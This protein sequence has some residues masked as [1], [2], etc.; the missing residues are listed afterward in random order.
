MWRTG[1]APAARVEAELLKIRDDVR[2]QLGAAHG[3]PLRSQ[4]LLAELAGAQGRVD[5]A[6]SRYREAIDT[7]NPDS[8]LYEEA[9]VVF[10]RYLFGL[11]RHSEVVEILTDK[12]VAQARGGT[13]AEGLALRGYALWELG[14]DRVGAR[15]LVQ[16][17][18][19][20]CELRPGSFPLLAKRAAAWLQVHTL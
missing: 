17:A 14:Q 15:T 3:I 4:L 5:N 13:H 1:R 7:A 18:A 6:E 19:A 9:L 16:D 10:A 11:S 8:A 12:R 2:G 20:H